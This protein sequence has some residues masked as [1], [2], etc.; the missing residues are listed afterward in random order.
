VKAPFQAV[1]SSG[2]CHLR[3][4][5][6]HLCFLQ[7][8]KSKDQVLQS[9]LQGPLW[10]LPSV[11]LPD[12]IFLYLV[13]LSLPSYTG[14]LTV[15]WAH[16]KCLSLE[17]CIPESC[18]WS[19]PWPC[20]CLTAS[21]TLSSHCLYLTFLVSLTLAPHLTLQSFP[22]PLTTAYFCLHLS[23]SNTLYLLLFPSLI[24]KLHSLQVESLC[25]FFHW[26]LPGAQNSVWHRRN[27]LLIYTIKVVEWV[28]ESQIC[29]LTWMGLKAVKIQLWLEYGILEAYGML[30]KWNKLFCLY[31]WRS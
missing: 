23:P 29:Y 22:I 5:C 9:V 20:P 19:D 8:S 14:L 21:P 12:L 16:Q 17:P 4:I 25:L 18:A 7:L 27:L 30:I 11:F 1:A 2:I 10:S 26:C 13:S 3:A 31:Y 6:L 15:P 24:N 28:T